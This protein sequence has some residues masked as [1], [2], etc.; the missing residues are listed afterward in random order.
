VLAGLK[1][2]EQ[3]VISPPAE[4]AEGMLVTVKQG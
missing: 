4:L 2:G 1:G 3:V